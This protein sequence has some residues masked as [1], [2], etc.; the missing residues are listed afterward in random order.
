MGALEWYVVNELI[1]ALALRS[2]FFSRL[3][4]WIVHAAAWLSVL[5]HKHSEVDVTTTPLFI[6]RGRILIYHLFHLMILEADC[7]CKDVTIVITTRFFCVP[8]EY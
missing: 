1:R 6:A 4:V 3:T 7:P 2:L 5:R 8:Y